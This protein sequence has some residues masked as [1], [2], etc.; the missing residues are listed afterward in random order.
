MASAFTTHVGFF[1]LHV[2][3]TERN[4]MLQTWWEGMPKGR[5]GLDSHHCWFLVAVVV[6]CC[7]NCP[8]GKRAMLLSWRKAF[9][10]ICS[11]HSNVMAFFSFRKTKKNLL[12]TLTVG[13]CR[14]H[15]GSNCK[16]CVSLLSSNVSV[17]RLWA[18]FA[19]ET[20]RHDSQLGSLVQHCICN[21]SLFLCE[22]SLHGY[23]ML[24]DT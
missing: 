23:S 1:F 16:S 24:P 20:T 12:L 15:T 21:I 2:L 18:C 9:Y 17:P 5:N 13:T 11:A 4:R 3:A 19:C 14:S 6:V 22:Y 10:C 8:K 7:W